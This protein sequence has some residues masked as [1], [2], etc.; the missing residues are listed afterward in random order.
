MKMKEKLEQY[1]NIKYIYAK[2]KI[3]CKSF[4]ISG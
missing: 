1:T 3:S 4:L 2:D